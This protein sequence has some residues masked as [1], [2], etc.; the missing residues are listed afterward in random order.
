M[1]DEVTI[2]KRDIQGEER[3][4]Y[5]G[6]IRERHPN[7]VVLEAHFNRPDTVYHG[8]P[9]KQ[10]DR[11][12]ETFYTDRWYN[13]MQ[14]FDRDDG[15][16]KGWYCNITLPT[17]LTDTTVEYTDLALDLF[18][19]PDGRQLVLDEDEF[20]ALAL[21]SEQRLKARAALVELQRIFAAPL[22]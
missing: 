19:Y 16:L 2:I 17:V 13:I 7:R 4:R 14:M 11:F 3:W 8:V 12:V 9:Y 6:V 15:S 21:T 20:A 18:V 5:S 10:G 22:G 1:S